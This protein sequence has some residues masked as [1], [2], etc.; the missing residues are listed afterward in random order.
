V[1]RTTQESALGDSA[2]G[3][4]TV[5]VVAARAAVDACAARGVEVEPVLR[6]ARLSR[7]ALASIEY[8]LPYGNVTRL[9]EAAAVAAGD[10]WF[11]V[12][13][14]ETLPMGAYDVLDYMFAAAA[15]AGDAVARIAEYF[16]LI[17]DQSEVRL[18]VEPRHARFVRRGPDAP[19]YDEFSLSL[20]LLRSRA[21]TATEW[22][23]DGVAF[24]HA[25]G[26]DTRELARVFR[27]PIVFG[28]SATEMRFAPSVLRLPHRGADSRL[29]DLLSRYADSLLRDVPRGGDLVAAVSSS[30]ARQLATRMPS[31][32]STAA[33]VHL[34]E[35][36]LQR[37][38][39]S[40]GETHSKLL[41]DVRRELALKYIGHAGLSILDIAYLLH[42]SDAT[43]FL[44]A[45]RRWTGEAPA[46]YRRRVFNGPM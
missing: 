24:Q 10:P 44:R 1:R 8:R 7:E 25:R 29:L 2:S 20:L 34:T 17:H 27:C 11:G 6:A 14:A 23:P 31:L 46:R 36:T 9:W 4:G 13:A 42:F 16:R 18:I 3:A 41:D 30:I 19:Q 33:A 39:A 35:R 15:T 21:A 26:A 43:S 45:F 32:A 37:R 12:H 5:S 28:A 40:R 22:T 38:L